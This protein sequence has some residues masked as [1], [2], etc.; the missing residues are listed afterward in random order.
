MFFLYGS[1]KNGKSTF[2]NAITAALN[3]YCRTAP[4][5]TFTVTTGERHPT[6]LAGLRGARLVTAVETEEGRHWAESKIKALT[7]GDKISARFMRQ[8]FFDYTPQFKLLIAG[9]HKPGLRSV[10]EAIRRRFFLIPFTVKI[11]ENEHDTQLLEKLKPVLPGILHWMDQGLSAMA[12]TRL[13]GAG[14]R[15]R[16]H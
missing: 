2:I 4:I 6:D 5:E 15:H 8:D 12:T 9:N 16:R 10:D 13:G 14:N 11:P 7:G 1:G 3:D